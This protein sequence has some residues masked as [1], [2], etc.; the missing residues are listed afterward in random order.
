MIARLIGL[1][2]V[3]WSLGFAAFML[4]LAQPADPQLTT[5]A[6]VVPTGGPGRIPRG[7]A[8]IEGKRA[9]RML[10]TGVATGLRKA[11]LAA[12]NGHEAAIAC[13]VDLGREA[14]DTRSNAEETARWMRE[15]GYKSVRLV[16]SDWHMAR[17]RMELGATL[18]SDVRIYRDGV[19]AEQRLGR[20][21]NEYNKLILRRI[22]LWAGIG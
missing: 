12:A 3:A 19:P 18:D 11:D 1:V 20:L 5:D 16:T 10:V 8:L 21:V 17:A 15:H 2:A 14:V 22:A 6:I 4:T 9:K 13:C 7:L